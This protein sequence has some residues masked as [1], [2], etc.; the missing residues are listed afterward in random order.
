MYRFGSVCHA[1]SLAQR[2]VDLGAVDDPQ[3]ARSRMRRFPGAQVEVEVEP[4]HLEALR[5]RNRRDEDLTVANAFDRV[6]T[7]SRNAIRSP[8]Y[9]SSLT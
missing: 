5:A 7:R 3:H 2:R 9:C 4:H 8:R 1:S 6:C